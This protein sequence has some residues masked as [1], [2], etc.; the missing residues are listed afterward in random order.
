MYINNHTDA[1]PAQPDNLDKEWYYNIVRSACSY[2][3]VD[4]ILSQADS[5]L[6]G[7]NSSLKSKQSALMLSSLD[8]SNAISIL[9]SP[10]FKLTILKDCLLLGAKQTQI[11]I[12]KLPFTFKQAGFNFEKDFMHPMWLAATRLLF[13]L[14]SDLCLELPKPPIVTLSNLDGSE[15][16][17]SAIYEAKLAELSD[18]YDFY[19]FIS[20]ITEAINAYLKC[21]RQYPSLLN[22]LTGFETNGSSH[23]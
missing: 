3:P 9:A 20:P 8:Y 18:K 4:Q 5:P 12:E 13:D 1:P 19:S 16:I 10:N 15:D 6:L 2:T 14:L 7:D 17:Y 23:R 11:T 22:Q 21:L